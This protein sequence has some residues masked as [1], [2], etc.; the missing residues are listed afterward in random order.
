MSFPQPIQGL[1]FT[2]LTDGNL[3]DNNQTVGTFLNDLILGDSG[4]DTLKGFAGKDAL[5]GNDGN[6][7]LFGGTGDD[8]LNGGSG[9]DKL[10]GGTNNDHLFGGDGDDELFGQANDDVLYGGRGNDLLDGGSGNDRLFGDAGD[11]TLL[12]RGQNDFIVGG[13]GDNLIQGGFGKDTIDLSQGGLFNQ[14]KV[15]Y[16]SRFEGGNNTIG[17]DTIINFDTD[18]GTMATSEEDLILVSQSGTNGVNGFG[19]AVGAIGRGT[20]TVVSGD[21]VT[22]FGVPV[23][24]FYGATSTTNARL[25]Y[26]ILGGN[27]NGSRTIAEFSGGLNG[28]GINESN[29][30]VIA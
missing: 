6:D 28:G 27:S 21:T 15:Q 25:D 3:F 11:D 26:D 10:F 9:E 24:R 13:A 8:F 29:I 23:F 7:E 1:I 22:S 19:V 5:F 18:S 2:D 16:I 12:G 20:V 14:D 17:Y 4:N 30:E